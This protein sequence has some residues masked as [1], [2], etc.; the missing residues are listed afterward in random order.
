MVLADFDVYILLELMN[1]L[2]LLAGLSV[3]ARNTCAV[4]LSA[5]LEKQCT[6]HVTLFP[7]FIFGVKQ[8][9]IFAALMYIHV[10]Y[11]CVPQDEHLI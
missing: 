2:R 1:L 5:H 11:P 7:C 8:N 10:K 3:P 9:T 6:L 4:Q